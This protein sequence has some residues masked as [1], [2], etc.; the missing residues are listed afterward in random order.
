MT[1]INPNYIITYSVEAQ[2]RLQHSYDT[3]HQVHQCQSYSLPWNCINIQ[4][5]I[6]LLIM[7]EL[8]P[9]WKY[10]VSSLQFGYGFGV[11]VVGGELIWVWSRVVG[12]LDSGPRNQFLKIFFLLNKIFLKIWLASKSSFLNIF[13]LK[14]SKFYML[15]WIFF[16]Q[17]PFDK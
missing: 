8:K 12:W 2:T 9:A 1:R 3:R 4:G 15:F 7:V 13:F 11:I 16:G 10:L 17:Y 5:I 14:C 6:F